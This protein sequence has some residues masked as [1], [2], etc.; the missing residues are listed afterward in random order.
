M[1]D[2]PEPKRYTIL[3]WIVMI[4]ASLCAVAIGFIGLGLWMTNM[5]TFA[6]PLSEE[7][8]DRLALAIF[9]FLSAGPFVAGISFVAGWLAFIARAPKL[10]TRIVFWPPVAWGLLMIAYILGI[11]WFCDGDFKCGL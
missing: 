10:G 1:T 8:V 11:G 5:M 7:P 4:L 2:G 3:R 9:L 6:S